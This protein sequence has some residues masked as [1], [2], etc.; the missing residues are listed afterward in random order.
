MTYNK[1]AFSSHC[2]DYKEYKEW[3]KNRNPVRYQQNKGKLFDRKNVA[4][5]V[6]L[7]HM[8]IEVAQGEGIKVDRTN[9]DRDFIMNIRNGNTSYEEIISYLENKRD[10]MERVMKTSKLPE[11]LIPKS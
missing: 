6:R 3:E 2:K 11:K 1:N 5:A 8:G 4:H 7:M 10:E 9:I